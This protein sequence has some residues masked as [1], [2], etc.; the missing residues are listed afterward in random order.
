MIGIILGVIIFIVTIPIKTIL[1]AKKVKDVGVG[2]VKFVKNS[3]EKIRETI[4]NTDDKTDEEK[5]LDGKQRVKKLAKTGVN[6]TKKAIDLTI[7][8]AILAVKA[9]I[10]FART[11]AVIITSWGAVSLVLTSV[12][13]LMIISSVAGAG[14]VL[15]NVV[16]SDENSSSSSK[17][18]L[19]KS[20]SSNNNSNS[21]VN[22][23]EET[24]K[25]LEMND[26]EVWS[27]ITEGRFK[28][29]SE[30]NTWCKSVGQTEATRYFDGLMTT[31][32]FPCWKWKSKNST[33]KISGKAKVRISKHLEKYFM[34]YLTDLYN[35]D[36]KYVVNMIGG[37]CC[38]PKRGSGNYSAHSFGAAID[39]NWD[40]DGMGYKQTPFNTT[41]NLKDQQK[42]EVCAFNES[43]FGLIKKY[44]LDWG[45]NWSSGSLDPMHFS[46]VGDT[47]LEGRNF[48]P[49]TSGRSK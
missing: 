12:I 41:K 6:L 17:S 13:S 38:R 21:S 48:T 9:T 31:I 18:S 33:E 1:L 4:N 34:D 35:L 22:Q 26:E 46:L 28:N 49:K 11:V 14:V 37:Y 20:N 25:I 45:G 29:Y 43:W 16:V 10:V 19:N 40:R 3:N 27:L 7:K 32:E 8:A 44:R 2:T 30:A 39:F 47:K 24:K 36:E 5:E 15:N 42:S 23:S